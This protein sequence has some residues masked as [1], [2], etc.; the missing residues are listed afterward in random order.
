M[1]NDELEKEQKHSKK[2][3]DGLKKEEKDKN[4][5]ENKGKTEIKMKY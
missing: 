2:N 4:I 1:K 3:D 5:D